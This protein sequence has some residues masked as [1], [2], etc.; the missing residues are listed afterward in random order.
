M[1]VHSSAVVPIERFRKGGLPLIQKGSTVLTRSTKR[2]AI[3]NLPQHEYSSIK[4]L[5][6]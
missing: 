5:K 6:K 1:E 2:K 4:K 3:K